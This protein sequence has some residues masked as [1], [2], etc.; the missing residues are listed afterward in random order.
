MWWMWWWRWWLWW[1][2]VIIEIHTRDSLR[3]P[4]REATRATATPMLRWG[5]VLD[6]AELLHDSFCELGGS[7]GRH[8]RET[9]LAGGEGEAAMGGEDLLGWAVGVGCSLAR[10]VLVHEVGDGRVRDGRVGATAAE[11]E[12]AGG[13]GGGGGGGGWSQEDALVGGGARHCNH[14]LWGNRDVVRIHEKD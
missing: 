2:G 9:E 8:V 12:G 14:K 7:F 11:G 1:W 3:D 13:Q 6:V 10:S 5:A 4:G